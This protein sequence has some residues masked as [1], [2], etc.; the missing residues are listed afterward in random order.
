MTSAPA[1]APRP[2]ELIRLDSLAAT[3]AGVGEAAGTPPAVRAPGS[4]PRLAPAISGSSNSASLAGMR[5]AMA[6]PAPI[7][8]RQSSASVRAVI[9]ASRFNHCLRCFP[10]LQVADTEGIHHNW[11]ARAGN[12][13]N[14]LPGKESDRAVRCDHRDPEGSAQ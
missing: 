1:S 8:N 5:R 4:A 13:A 12:A 3:P 2:P 7:V 6:A 11:K 9:R 14:Q 10:F